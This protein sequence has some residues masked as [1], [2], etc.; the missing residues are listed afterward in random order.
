MY[1]YIDIYAYICVK[2]YCGHFVCWN[3]I[4]AEEVPSCLPSLMVKNRSFFDLY[5]K[6]RP[7]K[8]EQKNENNTLFIKNLFSTGNSSNSN[9]LIKIIMKCTELHLVVNVT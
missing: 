3:L 4:A 9:V 6:N 1:A 5:H 7:K 8:F 2:N